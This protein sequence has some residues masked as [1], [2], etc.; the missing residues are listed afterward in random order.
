MFNL[1]FYIIIIHFIYFVFLI[2]FYFDFKFLKYFQ[3]LSCIINISLCISIY[4]CCFVT[5]LRALKR[6]AIYPFLGI[7]ICTNSF[8][9]YNN[10]NIFH[11]PTHH[12]VC[13]RTLVV[14]ISGT[15]GSNYSDVTAESGPRPYTIPVFSSSSNHINVLYL[16]NNFITKTGFLSI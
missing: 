12:Y 15:T 16:N 9:R 4:I 10:T 11:S 8:S 7:L 3:N 1:K 13:S 2:G 14:V 5:T 6:D